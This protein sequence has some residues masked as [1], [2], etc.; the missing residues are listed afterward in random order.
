VPGLAD[1][2]AVSAGALHSLALTGDR[3]VMAWGWNA[4]GQLGTGSTVDRIQPVAIP[5]LANIASISG[6]ALHSV[7]IQA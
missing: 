6:G 2:S 4:V 7:A 5:T 3:Q 1:V